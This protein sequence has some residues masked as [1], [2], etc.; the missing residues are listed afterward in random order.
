M[1]IIYIIAKNQRN[2]NLKKEEK[3]IDFIYIKRK[4]H[5]KNKIKRI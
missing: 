2:R 5:V 1:W 3:G 4:E